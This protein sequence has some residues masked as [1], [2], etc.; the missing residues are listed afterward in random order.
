MGGKW[1]ATF[2]LPADLNC[3]LKATIGGTR[4][5]KRELS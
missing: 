5:E 3:I 1:F 2:K 4:R